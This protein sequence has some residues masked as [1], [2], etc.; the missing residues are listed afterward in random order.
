ML[1]DVGGLIT[2]I[3]G[4]A[5]EINWSKGDSPTQITNVP[6]EL[7]GYKNLYGYKSLAPNSISHTFKT[8]FYKVLTYTEFPRNATPI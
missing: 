8:K 7:Y 3:I 1:L 6:L 2:A 5:I 4:G